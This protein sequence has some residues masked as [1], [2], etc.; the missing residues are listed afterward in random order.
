MVGVVVMGFMVTEGEAESGFEFGIMT[1]VVSAAGGAGVM[2]GTVGKGVV[3][4]LCVVEIGP[5]CCTSW[6]CVLLVFLRA[7]LWV[8]LKPEIGTS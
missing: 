3:M 4:S 1:G 5:F 8:I 6:C 7:S 2:V